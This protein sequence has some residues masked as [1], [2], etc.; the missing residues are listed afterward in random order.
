LGRATALLSA[1]AVLAAPEWTAVHACMC[2]VRLL[3]T[4]KWFKKILKIL[5][6]LSGRE[7]G[8]GSGDTAAD[9]SKPDL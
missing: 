3:V 9:G 1:V 6:K 7:W 8:Q 5:T 2:V 4:E